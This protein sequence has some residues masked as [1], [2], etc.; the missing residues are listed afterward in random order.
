[1]AE[2]ETAHAAGAAAQAANSSPGAA[3]A[4]GTAGQVADAGAANEQI[5][6]LLDMQ[7]PVTARLGR[8]TMKVRDLMQ[9][10]EGT[11]LKLDRLA[12]EPVDLMLRGVK[13][14]VGDLVVVGQKLGVRVR[15]IIDQSAENTG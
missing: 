1:M 13:F 4:A 3:H 15:R 7:M 11:V 12:G 9:L 6:I 2:N 14:A 10:G 5:N 8:A